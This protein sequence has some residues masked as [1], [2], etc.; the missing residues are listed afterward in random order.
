ML[1]TETRSSKIQRFFSRTPSWIPRRARES[2]DRRGRTSMEQTPISSG[3][4]TAPG[5]MKAPPLGLRALLLVGLVIAGAVVGAYLLFH[6]SRPA[7]PAPSG[8]GSAPAAPRT[9]VRS[10]ERRVGKE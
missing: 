3:S 6:R 5:P 9:S 8:G 10:E 1:T 2:D 4:S 7:S